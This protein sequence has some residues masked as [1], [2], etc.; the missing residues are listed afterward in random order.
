MV[1][2]SGII[3]N[4]SRFYTGEGIY[5]VIE[6]R[7]TDNFGEFV[8]K[9]EENDVKYKFEFFDTNLNLIKTS[10]NVI[11]LCDSTYCTL[12]FVIETGTDVFDEF[13]NISSFSSTLSFDNSTNTFTYAWDDKRDETG[14]IIRL[15]VKRYQLNGTETICNNQS[16]SKLSVLT[17]NVGDLSA[18]YRTQVYRSVPGEDERR[19]TTMSVKVNDPSS[20]YGVEGLL[21]AFILL[22]TCIAIGAYNPSVGIVLY[23]AGFILLG[24][25]GL[26]SMPLAVFFA[27]TVICAVFLWAIKT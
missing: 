5:R 13:S 24:V 17:C 16:T 25:V 6:R 10:D 18:S 12:S 8:S 14:S 27:N 2:A 11:I 22:F 20:T 26:I 4:I 15:E 3:V 21:W 23:G 1:V 19:V 7:V 9:L